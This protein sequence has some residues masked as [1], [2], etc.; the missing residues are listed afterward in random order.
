MSTPKPHAGHDHAPH[1]ALEDPEGLPSEHE[2][3]EIALRELLIEKE[4][5]GAAEVSRMIE[6][7]ETRNAAC[8]AKLVSRI[9]T[10]PEF[11][12][13]ALDNG[14]AAVEAELGFNMIEAP[15]LIV[16]ENRP[17]LHHVLVCTLCSCYP[18][19]VLGASPTWYRSKE[20]R[21]RVVREPRAVL[22]EFGTELPDDVEIRVVDSTAEVRYLIVPMRPAG[23]EGWSR[24]RL[25][26]LVSRDSLIGV[27]PALDPATV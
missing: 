11:R 10:D 18:I 5:I 20:Y 15:E 16:L 26:K 17:K 2:I 19:H 9:W 3:L 4:V 22:A 8:G 23:T 27:T 24:E 14:K 1:A 7:L 21:A 6:A 25:E 13:L 12:K